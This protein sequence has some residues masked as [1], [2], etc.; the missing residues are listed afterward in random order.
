MLCTNF[1]LS[2]TVS[3]CNTHYLKPTVPNLSRYLKYGVSATGIDKLLEFQKARHP[4]HCGTSQSHTTRIAEFQK[5][6]RTSRV[7]EMMHMLLLQSLKC[8]LQGFL[9]YLLIIGT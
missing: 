4:K 3:R 2:D 5:N 9:A 8:L 6:L 7:R 1:K